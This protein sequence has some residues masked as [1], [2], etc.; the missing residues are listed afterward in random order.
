[1]HITQTNIIYGNELLLGHNKC[2]YTKHQL[3][4]QDKYIVIEC[5]KYN[6]TKKVK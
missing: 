6:I 2:M 1:M 5:C 3:R 4:F